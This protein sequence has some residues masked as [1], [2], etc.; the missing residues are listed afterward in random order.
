MISV[1]IPMLDLFIWLSL[2]SVVVKIHTSSWF[3]KWMSC[4]CGLDS[5]KEYLIMFWSLL[6]CTMYCIIHNCCLFKILNPLCC[7]VKILFTND[8]Q[9]RIFLD[10]HEMDLMLLLLVGTAWGIIWFWLDF[11]YRWW[12]KWDW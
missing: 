1:S 7:Q 12:S 8:C 11:D 10:I 5:L 2:T 3:T 6:L 9:E 4:C